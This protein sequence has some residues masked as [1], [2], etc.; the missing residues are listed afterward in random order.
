[1][2]Q[3]ELYQYSNDSVNLEKRTKDETSEVLCVK[4]CLYGAETLTLRRSEEK[5]LE[6]FEMWICRMVRVKWTGRIRNEAV[7]QRIMEKKWEYKGT[8]HQLFIDFK[9]AYN[10]V[11]REVLY[12]IPIEFGIPKEL[13]RLIKMCL[14]KT[15]SRVRIEYAIRKVQDNRED[16]ELNGIH[17]LLVYGDDVN[18]LG[19]NP[20]TIRENT[21]I[22]L[23]ASKAIS[24]EVNPEKT[25][26]MIM[27]RAWPH[28]GGV[29]GGGCAGVGGGSGSSTN[30]SSGGDG[31]GGSGGVIFIL[32]P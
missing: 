2:C 7:L 20:K 22:L 24:L 26:Y 25:K 29:D 11:K 18:M 27:S 8:V 13:V 16:L 28:S 12:D 1:M 9:K 23:E 14:S 15:Y 6:A 21:G 5:Q 19:E 10:S 4:C 31:G 17:Q 3:T 32:R 30:I